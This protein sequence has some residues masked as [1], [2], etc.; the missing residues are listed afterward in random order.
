MSDLIVTEINLVRQFL[1]VNLCDEQDCEQ[2]IP[3]WS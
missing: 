2:S 3:Y 1:L